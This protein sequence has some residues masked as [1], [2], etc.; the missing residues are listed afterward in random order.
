MATPSNSP[1]ASLNAA[2][3]NFE[4]VLNTDEKKKLRDIKAIPDA[5]AAILFT[6]RLDQANAER[7][8]VSLG[9]R[10]YSVLLSVQQFANVVGT[11]V[12]SHPEI[13]A[14]VWGSMQLTMLVR[15]NLHSP[16]PRFRSEVDLNQITANF[17]HYFQ[18]L[19][20]IVQDYGEWSPR[21]DEYRLLFPF[22]AQ[23]QAAVCDF[24]AALVDCCREIL[25][26][27]R[28]S[29]R[30]SRSLRGHFDHLLIDEQGVIGCFKA[31]PQASR[32][33]YRAMRRFSRRKQK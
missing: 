14:L 25:L 28:R 9:S 15:C 21:F 26:M 17:T 13:A 30:S 29:C 8:G 3:R 32:Q 31:L 27:T 4:S 10:V 23:L 5:D 19:S 2:L 22:S 12:S 33:K 24:H 18:K 20:S 6:A 7:R 11:F 1:T 16:Q